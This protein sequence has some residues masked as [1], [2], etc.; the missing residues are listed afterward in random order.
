MQPDW[1]AQRCRKLGDAI[2]GGTDREVLQA[3][4]HRQWDGT[5]GCMRRSVMGPATHVLYT[6][7]GT[8]PVWSTITGALVLSL[9]RGGPAPLYATTVT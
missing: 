7:E 1:T 2:G 8:G 3:M 9:V 6:I 5:A 4:R